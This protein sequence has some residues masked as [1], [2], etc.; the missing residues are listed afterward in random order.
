MTMKHTTP[1]HARAWLTTV[2][3]P[4]VRAANEA[5]RGH[6]VGFL[7]AH[8][9]GEGPAALRCEMVTT[10]RGTFATGHIATITA[11]TSGKA[12]ARLTDG[13]SDQLVELGTIGVADQARVEKLLV[14]F[15]E[16][17]MRDHAERQQQKR[18]YPQPQPSVGVLAKAVRDRVV[19]K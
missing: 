2:A 11:T 5:L 1:A 18:R 15:A 3:E 14:D 9:R 13:R 10:M 19:G 6:H 7:F 16:T 4:G 17:A 12:I 8:S